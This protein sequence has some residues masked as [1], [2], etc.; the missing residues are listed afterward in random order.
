MRELIPIWNRLYGPEGPDTL[1]L[2]NNLA[3]DIAKQGRYPEAEKMYRETLAV[4][5]RIPGRKAGSTAI[6]TYNLACLAEAQGRRDEALSLLNE[7]LEKDLPPTIAQDMENDEDLKSMHGDPRFV[8]L[9]KRARQFAAA[10]QG[11]N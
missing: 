3:V 2:R 6:T 4:Q 5:K 7:A 11:K 8:E 9:V 1:E 10:A